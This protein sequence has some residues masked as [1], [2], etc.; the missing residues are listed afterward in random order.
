LIIAGLGVSTKGT[1]G[2][3]GRYRRRPLQGHGRTGD[4]PADQ[5]INI[6]ALLVVPLLAG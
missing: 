3:D 1:G 5:T 2:G 6:V 4:Q